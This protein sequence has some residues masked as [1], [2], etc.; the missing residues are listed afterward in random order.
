MWCFTSQ[1]RNLRLEEAQELLYIYIYDSGG[2]QRDDGDGCDIANQHEP[3]TL[4]T[5]TS[6]SS[7]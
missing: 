1:T 4:A 5:L 6:A 2:K 7:R 3:S